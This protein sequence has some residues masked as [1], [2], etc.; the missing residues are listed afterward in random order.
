[1]KAPLVLTFGIFTSGLSRWWPA[2]L[3]I[4]KPPRKRVLLEPR[5]GGRWFEISQD[6]T[7]TVVAR[8]IVWEPPDR[9]VFLWQV[10]SNLQADKDVK[11]Q[12]DV[13]FEMNE[14]TLVELT[15]DFDLMSVDTG[16]KLREAFQNLWPPLLGRFAT[17]VESEATLL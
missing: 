1:V 11:S 12:V 4:G 16:A 6:E 15:H 14:G 10:N 5:L 7:R 17:R 3:V 2:S 9:A 13:R 8:I